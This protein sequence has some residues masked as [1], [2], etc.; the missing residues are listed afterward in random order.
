LLEE[1][2]VRMRDGRIISGAEATAE[3]EAEEAQTKEPGWDDV[4]FL[5]S[6]VICSRKPGA[7]PDTK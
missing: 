3:Y 4:S 5:D 6:I 7:S 2:K 1:V